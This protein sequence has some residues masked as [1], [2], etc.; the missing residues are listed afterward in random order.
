M[1]SRIH[2]PILERRFWIK[3]TTKLV[4]NFASHNSPWIPL[5]FLATKEPKLLYRVDRGGRDIF[6][7]NCPSHYFIQWCYTKVNDVVF[8]AK[9][10]MLLLAMASYEAN[11]QFFKYYT[12]LLWKIMKMKHHFIRTFSWRKRVQRRHSCIFL[13]FYIRLTSLNSIFPAMV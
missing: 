10:M 12:S 2:L 1:K 3:D 6:K 11:V 9:V 7:H 4:S 8:S 13:W 5:K